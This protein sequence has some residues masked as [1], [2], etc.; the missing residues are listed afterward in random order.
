MYVFQTEDRNVESSELHGKKKNL[1][2]N[3]IST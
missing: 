2:Q 1:S 3:V